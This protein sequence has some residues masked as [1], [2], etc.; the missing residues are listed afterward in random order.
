MVKGTLCTNGLGSYGD[1]VV[2]DDALIVKLF[3]DQGGIP[4]VKGNIPVG[5]LSYHSKNL[6]WGEAKNPWNQE[7]S[8]GG[9]SGGDAALIAANCV[10]FGIGSDMLGSLRIP[11]LF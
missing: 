6:I 3:K 11:A 7:R 10:P 2:D 5:C 9:S 1:N 8:C 4:L